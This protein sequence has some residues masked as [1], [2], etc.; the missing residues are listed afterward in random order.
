MQ[1]ANPRNSKLCAFCECWRGDCA[2][3]FISAKA[4]Y[5]FDGTASGRCIEK[6]GTVTH[7]GDSASSCNYYE[8][9]KDVRENSKSFMD[10]VGQFMGAFAAKAQEIQMYKEQYEAMDDAVLIQEYKY[11]KGKSGEE[12]RHRVTAIKMVLN[13][14]GYGNHNE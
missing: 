7:A 4:G 9:R 11:L 2:L 5:E 6:N 10:S 12:F 13:D 8:P 14:R 3:K 1:K